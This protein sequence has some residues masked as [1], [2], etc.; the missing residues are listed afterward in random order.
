MLSAN[1][2]NCRSVLLALLILMAVPAF[3]AEPAG[4]I[5]AAVGQVVVIRN[6]Q[7]SPLATGAAVEVG[8]QIKTGPASRAQILFTDSS[9]VAIKPQTDFLVT[10]YVFNGSEDGSEKSFFSL[11]RGG[12]VTVTG[13]IGHVHKANYAI[14]TP[15][16]T[17]GIRGTVWGADHCEADECQNSDGSKAKPG[18]YGQVKS[19]VIAVT[20]NTPEV[21]FGAGSAFYVANADT[22]P[23]RLLV[24]P[25]FVTARL[26]APTLN[27]TDANSGGNAGP[28]AVAS[29]AAASASAALSA[30]SSAAGTSAASSSGSGTNDVGLTGKTSGGSG[31]GANTTI[32]AGW[33]AGGVDGAIALDAISDG[34]AI[35]TL[36]SSIPLGFVVLNNTTPSGA[37]ANSPLALQGI[38]A[39]TPFFFTPGFFFQLGNGPLEGPFLSGLIDLASCSGGTI[40]Q[41][42]DLVPG[43]KGLQLISLTGTPQSPATLTQTAPLAGNGEELNLG[44]AGQVYVEELKGP[45]AGVVSGMAFNGNM[46]TAFLYL[47]S[48]NPLLGN[49]GAPAAA[50]GSYSFGGPG[51]FIGLA[52]D[53]AGNAG[54]ISQFSGSFNA[55]KNTV[56]FSAVASVSVTGYGIASFSMSSSGYIVGYGLPTIGLSQVYPAP[57]TSLASFS[58]Q[59]AT[60]LSATCTGKGCAGPVIPYGS[61]GVEFIGSPTGLA[62]MAVQGSV[63]GATKNGGAG[64]E[65]YFLGAMK[66]VSGHC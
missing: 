52:T 6:G 58:N 44:H 25:N 38:Y 8:D 26:T 27:A 63:L 20:N 59:F 41:D 46:G 14:R 31:S 16:A 36:A 37:P 34:R 62:A 30:S 13:L 23:E 9:I 3:C 65:L 64:N 54:S 7:A 15:A 50:S 29:A 10:D 28:S 66:C 21:E 1:N 2:F 24:A 4:R 48:T 51:A 53:S 47:A 60:Q 17:I 5:L 61:W 22:P 35:P 42:G 55:M 40:C 33:L 49:G 57:L 56:S 32:P 39:L 19:G 43:F 12:L 45:Y 18:T 11:I